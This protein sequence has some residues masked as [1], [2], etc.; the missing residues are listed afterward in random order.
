[1]AQLQAQKIMIDSALD[2]T[3]D[4]E[5]VDSRDNLSDL[6]IF[7]FVAT[8][9]YF[10]FSLLVLLQDISIL[11]H[12]CYSSSDLNCMLLDVHVDHHCSYVYYICIS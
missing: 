10:Y 2:R 4:F 5:C 11:I 6:H 9:P 7:Q 8:F 12:F 3:G 1:M